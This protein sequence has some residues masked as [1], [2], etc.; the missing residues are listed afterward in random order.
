VFAAALAACIGLAGPARAQKP[1]LAEM[2]RSTWTARDGAPQG[3]TDLAQAPDGTLWI[4]TVGGLFHFDGRAFTAFQARAGEPQLPAESVRSL[5]VTRDGTLWVSFLHAALARIARGRVTLYRNFDVAPDTQLVNTAEDLREARDGSVWAIANQYMLIR[6]DPGAG[7]WRADA[8][9]PPDADDRASGLHVD[10]SN[11]LWLVYGGRLFRRQLPETTYT[12]TDVP[13]GVV[14]RFAELPGGDIWM[15]YVDRSRDRGRTVR[16]D[17]HGRSLVSLGHPEWAG[18]MLHTPDGLLLFQNGGLHRY[19]VDA[20]AGR[21]TLPRVSD[22]LGVAQG[23]TPAPSTLLLDADRNIWVGG[24]RGLQ[25]LRAPRLVPFLPDSSAEGSALCASSRG[26]VFVVL[27]SNGLYRVAGGVAEKIPG[28]ERIRGVSCGNDGRTRAYDHMN[29]WELREGRLERIPSIPGLPPYSMS[30]VMATPDHTLYATVGGHPEKWGGVWRYRDGEWTK[31]AA[32]GLLRNAGRVAYLDSRAR[33]WIGY[34]RGRIGLPLEG[35]VLRSG[36][37]GLDNVY[38]VLESS[39]GL[40]AGGTNGVA[41]LRDTSFQMLTFTDRASARG[42][43]GLVESRNGD[44]WLNGVQGIVRVP[45]AELRAGL[46]DPRHPMRSERVAEGDFTGPARTSQETATAVR[47]ADGTLWFTMLNGVVSYDP[48]APHPGGRPP[49]LSIRSITAD[50]MPLGAD[51]AFDP[52]PR[53]LEIRY[54]GVNLTAPDR[55][56]YRYRLDGFDDEWHD[57]GGR[58]EAIY[59]RPGPG[60]YTFRVMAANEAGAW[61]AP[62]S[63]VSFTVLPSFHQTPWFAALVAAAIVALGW[64]AYALRVRSI[65][66]VVQAR[67]EERADERM[68]IARELHDTLLS[69]MAGLMMSL[70]AIAWRARA[71]GGVDPEA[72]DVLCDQTHRTLV[73]AREAVVAM[74]ASTDALLPLH[75]RLG[76]TAGRIFTGTGVDVRVTPS[77]TPRPLPPEVDE[78][79]VRVAAE[80]MTNARAHA[81]C[82]VVEVT[83]DYGRRGL[84]VRVRDD[85][86]GFDPAVACADGHYGLVGM[87]ER[88]D[89]IGARLAVESAPGA[90]TTVRLEVPTGQTA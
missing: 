52:Q 37:P 44:L 3:I 23:L 83:C 7:V 38:V 41:V 10:A 15:T 30:E 18:D 5:L 76:D 29:F 79:V 35:R 64:L 86:R 17:R 1:A 54:F 25:R 65:T 82:R 57:A 80:A 6:F 9:P 48:D 60:T 45:A 62:V 63:S 87:R 34:N 75:R 40:F 77:G 26:D 53:T 21:S 50:R 58:T 89:A 61:T 46:A 47:G 59:T 39:R 73:E 27:R 67:A 51:R 36:S 19:R 72:L 66:A 20:L 8:M 71:P 88:A 4:G 11:V 16:F 2:D 12:K 90:G 78:Q 70:S 24:R 84:V 81:A 33:L 22:S 13:A 43:T 69:G 56:R 74:R 49:A 55:V 32:E 31:H 28:S 42:V 14:F 68:R 85:G